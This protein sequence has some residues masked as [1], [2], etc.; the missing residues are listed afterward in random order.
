MK[1]A[2]TVL[3]GRSVFLR[4]LKEEDFGEFVALARS[5]ARFHR[6]LMKL[7]QTKEAFKAFIER[8]SGEASECFVIC[9]RSDGAIAGIINMSQI[10]RGPLKSAYLGY[11]LG[12]DFVGNGFATEAVGLVVQFAFRTLKLH[13]LEANIQPHN[14][15][16]IALVKRLGFTKEGYSEKYLKI[17]GKWRDHERWAII[18]EN[19]N[20][21]G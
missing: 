3:K 11:G 9:R 16:S 12:K 18:K 5:S 1:K 2:E 6:G 14:Q 13:R 8:V 20:P 15:R 4:R 7:P 21:N 19:W 17:G 10:F